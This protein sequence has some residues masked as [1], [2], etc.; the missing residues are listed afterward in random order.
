M[1]LPIV[2]L[3]LALFGAT[4]CSSL[5]TQPDVDKNRAA[6]VNAELGL[7]YMLQGDMEIAMEK[8]QRSLEFNSRYAPA[9]HYLAEL[10]RN[11]NRIDDAEKHYSL[12]VRHSREEDSSLYNNYGV[13]LCSRGRYDEGE[14][15][16]LKVLE[17]PVY[18][19]PERVYENLG[20]C[21]ESKGDMVKAEAYLRQSLI[22]N[23][24]SAPSLLAMARL[25]FAQENY[26]S[27]RAHLQRYREVAQH[28]PE[29][30][31]LGVRTERILGDRNALASYGLSLQRNFPNAEETRKYLES[32]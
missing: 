2:V 9:H 21:L 15:Q 13:F 24:R 17:N 16:L 29:T 31:W 6:E 10:Y 28:T 30:L 8:L 11:L 12:A 27:T 26:L 22:R 7:S 25:S 5:S 3:S 14:K 32:R 19:Y 18:P 23:S 4:G 1:K 20:L